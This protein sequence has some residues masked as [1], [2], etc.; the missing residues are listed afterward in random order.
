MILAGKSFTDGMDAFEG[1]SP[2][3]RCCSCDVA[4]LRG[5]CSCPRNTVL[6]SKYRSTW[7][8]LPEGPPA[9]IHLR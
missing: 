9:K 6:C 4:D 3:V 8:R 7:A 1:L 2:Q 5:A